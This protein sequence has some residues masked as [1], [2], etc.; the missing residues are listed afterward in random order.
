MGGSVK[1]VSMQFIINAFCSLWQLKDLIVD[2]AKN[3][4]KT[5]Y[6][7]SYFGILWAFIQPV[8]TILVFW[9]VFE[10]GFRSGKVENVPFVLWFSCGLIPWFFFADAWVNAT[11]SFMEYNYLVK[12][13]QFKI[14]VLP[15]IKILSSLFVHIF[16]VVFLISLFAINGYKPDIFTVQL[17]YY[18]FCT[19]LL[20][21]SLSYL[22]A[23]IIPFFRDLNQI[24]SIILQFGM[25]MTPV[26]WNYTM[27]PEKY[28]WL[29]TLNPMF[30]I[31]EGYRETLITKVWFWEHL[32]STLL[33]W[34]I[35]V[36]SFFLGALAF[37][38]LKSHFADVL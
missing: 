33:F 11:N 9:F 3:D 16:F 2:L 20:V 22:T 1:G 34:S 24:I 25:W 30:Y 4:F 28:R 19:I 13:I 10:V 27:V 5:R 21:G 31:V 15:V 12:K 14:S 36:T 32:T 37:K 8:M 38:K 35:T 6:A 7:G 26:M 18:T 23:S 17:L 29:F